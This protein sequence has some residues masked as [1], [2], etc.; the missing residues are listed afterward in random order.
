MS[1]HVPGFQSFFSFI[2]SFYNS[3]ISH[4]QHIYIY[5]IDLIATWRSLHEGSSL[6]IVK[7]PKL[8]VI[9]L[10]NLGPLDAGSTVRNIVKV[11][12]R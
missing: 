1:T 3:K 2:V 7:F 8:T 5:E 10:T 4:Q 9:N 11:T 12:Y 6:R